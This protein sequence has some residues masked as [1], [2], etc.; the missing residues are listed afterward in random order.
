MNPELLLLASLVL[1]RLL[2]EP[3]AKLHPT[4]YMGRAIEKLGSLQR[5]RLA[6]GVLLIL[7][8]ALSSALIA[9]LLLTLL[10]GLAKALVALYLLKTSLSWR[11]LRDFALPVKEAIEGGDLERARMLLVQLVSR[12][13]EGLD[14]EQASSAPV[15]S[16]A[17]S[18][19]DGSL[20]PVFYFAIFSCA[21]LEAGVGAA[22]FYRGVNTLDAMV[23]Y[24]SYGPYGLPSARL[25]DLLNFIPA[26]ISA[27]LIALI[28]PSRRV[29]FSMLRRYGSTKGPNAALPIASMAGALG[30]RLS[31]PG[32]YSIGEGREPRPEDIGAALGLADRVV[33]LFAL[34]TIALI[35]VLCKVS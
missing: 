18:I 8:V 16:I 24:S 19:H 33:A 1:D 5:Y 32:V 25:D 12:P 35:H 15:E 34:V 7:L 28:S 13:T 11:G 22:I 23:G 26:R 30:L 10:E 27:L 21:S 14:R 31:K 3:R 4:I 6:G 9:Y 17:E 29:N 20:S 2:G